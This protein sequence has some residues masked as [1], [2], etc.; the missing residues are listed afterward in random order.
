MIAKIINRF[1]IMNLL[2]QQ[3]TGIKVI[4]FYKCDFQWGTHSGMFN[5]SLISSRFQK[6]LQFQGFRQSLLLRKDSP[7]NRQRYWARNYVGYQYFSVR[8]PNEN[9]QRIAELQKA[10][11]ITNLITQN[12]D[13]LHIKERVYLM[14]KISYGTCRSLEFGLF[15]K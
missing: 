1:C 4:T 9:H 10:G 6:L 5:K 15:L 11:Y 3:H 12:V 13:G 14:R 7:W 2:N 8:K